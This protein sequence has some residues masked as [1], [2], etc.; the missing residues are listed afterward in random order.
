MCW[1]LPLGAVAGAPSSRVGGAHPHRRREA[2]PQARR[3][4]WQDLR[5]LRH[6]TPRRGAREGGGLSAKGLC[7]ARQGLGAESV[8]PRGRAPEKVDLRQY[9]TPARPL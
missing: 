8:L 2:R 6:G 1:R 3:D 4:R 7:A 9:M 5:A